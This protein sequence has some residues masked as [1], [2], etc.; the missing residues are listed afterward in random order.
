MISEY[1]APATV[2]DAVALK[3][4]L[5]D[6]AVYLAGGTEVN[7]AAFSGVPEH[8]ISLER[9]GLTGI[10]SAGAELTIGACCTIQEIIASAEVPE[11]IR[12]AGQHVVNRNIRNLAT[13]GGQLGSNKSCGNLLPMLIVLEAVVEVASRGATEAIPAIE[14]VAG[15]RKE[16]ILRVRIPKHD[17]SRSVA[18]EK[19]ARTANDLSVVTAGVSVARDGELIDRPLIAAGGVAEHVIRL[20]AVERAL[21][22]LPLPSR[23][24]IEELVGR[25]V[26][27][28]ADI[29]GGVEFR[30]HLA[31]VLV[32]KALHRAYQGA[33][34]ERR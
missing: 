24:A 4:R 34:G 17:R 8:V 2:E 31:G 3:E 28:I 18:V 9:L 5:A 7:S 25:N 16:L 33:G 27:P 1:H 26:S 21:H 15:E 12:E 32:A 14:Y 19:Y 29:R 20:E 6:S 22:G 13:I 30:R 10:R 23:E 11:C